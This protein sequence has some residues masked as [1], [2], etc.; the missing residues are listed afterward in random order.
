[1]R[2]LRGSPRRLTSR[3]L[4]PRRQILLVDQCQRDG[5]DLLVNRSPRRQ[6]PGRARICSRPLRR[7][8]VEV[9]YEKM[10]WSGMMVVK[11]FFR[12]SPQ[13]A[14][15]E[16]GRLRSSAG[17]WDMGVYVFLKRLCMEAGDNTKSI[18]SLHSSY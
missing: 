18:N 2:S 7:P 15:G 1:M 5:I 8:Q 14:C 10:N 12:P 17:R 13:K 6:P 3:R 11:V 9:L 4:S 16:S